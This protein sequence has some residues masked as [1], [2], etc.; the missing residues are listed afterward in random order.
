MQTNGP[1]D[2]M[3]P[4][5]Q[6]TREVTELV[7][8]THSEL[9]FRHSTRVYLWG[10]MLGRQRRL[11]FDPELLYVASM[12]HD[13]GLTPHYHDSQLRFEVDGANAARDFL[14]SHR[15]PEA[16]VQKVWTAVALHTTPGIPEH[17]H[18]EIALVHA[19]AGMDVAGRGFEQF[20]DAQRAAVVGAYPRGDNFA[21]EM[22]DAFYEGMKH[23]PA[24]TFGTFNDDFLAH[25]DP[26]FA[27]I[28]V[29]SI[30]LRSRW[31]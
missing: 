27:R 23:R 21:S 14:R 5:S 2:D 6:L 29:C 4:D 8:D 13:I 11:P 28:D 10:A 15:V 12:F 24:T 19:G 9:L 18:A 25:K 31:G 1:I 30:I 26:A 16:D 17:M 20:T 3:I 7:R 22:I